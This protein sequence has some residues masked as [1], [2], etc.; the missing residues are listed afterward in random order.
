MVLADFD[1]IPL[2]DAVIRE[3]LRFN[4]TIPLTTRVALADDVIPLTAPFKDR[5]GRVHHDI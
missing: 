2:L 4:P 5:N 3:T 1:K